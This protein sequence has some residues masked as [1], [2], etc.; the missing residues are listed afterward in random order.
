MNGTF[1]T[2]TKCPSPPNLKKMTKR[3]PDGD[4][5]LFLSNLP[6]P[7]PADSQRKHCP[8]ANANTDNRRTGFYRQ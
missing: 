4:A 8:K 3:Q 2:L 7:Q 5:P 1:S 6:N